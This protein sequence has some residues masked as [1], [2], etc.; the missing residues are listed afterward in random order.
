MLS[1]EI[2]RIANLV[3]QNSIDTDT[4]EKYMRVLG[5]PSQFVGM[6]TTV[7]QAA[8][9]WRQHK[10]WEAEEEL[11]RIELE[12]FLKTKPVEKSNSKVR[13]KSP[14][15]LQRREA[16]EQAKQAW[17]DAVAQRK[18]AFNSLSEYLDAE[19]ARL[20]HLSVETTQSWNKYVE[21]KRK[22]MNDLK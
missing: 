7:E 20:R 3:E 9:H 19:K 16:L 2:E 10:K 1:G 5:L 15:E 11:N 22:A 18:S 17:R 13:E 12:K 4:A 8:E 6:V 14:E 21:D